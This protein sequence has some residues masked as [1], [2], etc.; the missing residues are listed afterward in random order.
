M[1]GLMNRMV[2][3]YLVL[4]IND[5]AI[6]LLGVSI[7]CLFRITLTDRTAPV[8]SDSYRIYRMGISIDN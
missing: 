2:F 4:D 8:R 3:L 6:E 7:F 5:R 1:T